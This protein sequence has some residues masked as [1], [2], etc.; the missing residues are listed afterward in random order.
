MW[1]GGCCWLACLGLGATAVSAAVV[2]SFCFPFGG[3]ISLSVLLCL[4]V[5]SVIV[6][7]VMQ[8]YSWVC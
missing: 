7:A 1:I 2:A 6:L 8:E 3:E 4:H 5:L